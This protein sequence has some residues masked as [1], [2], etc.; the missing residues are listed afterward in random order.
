[1][2][3]QAIAKQA[4]RTSVVAASKLALVGLGR[5]RREIHPSHTMARRRR[6]SGPD[7]LPRPVAVRAPPSEAPDPAPPSRLGPLRRRRGLLAVQPGDVARRSAARLGRRGRP[8]P[9]RQLQQAPHHLLAPPGDAAPLHVLHRH[10]H[11][12]R[13]RRPRRGSRRRLACLRL[14]LLL[15][16]LVLALAV[17][18]RLAVVLEFDGDERIFFV[19]F[20]HIPLNDL[21]AKQETSKEMDRIMIRTTMIDE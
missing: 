1:M 20:L 3:N 17:P 21:F 6:P 7:D 19:L 5:Q 18:R 4:V 14:G 8:P 13:R 2:Y 10:H 12:R 9:A 11:G 16:R 15:R